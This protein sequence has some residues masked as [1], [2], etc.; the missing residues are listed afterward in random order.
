MFFDASTLPRKKNRIHRRKFKRTDDEM[1][2]IFG[3]IGKAFKKVGKVVKKSGIA[4]AIPGIG[5]FIQQGLDMIPEGG[6]G[7]GGVAKGLSGITTFGNQ[8]LSALDQLLAKPSAEAVDAAGQLVA[9]L[10]DGSKVYQPKKGKDAAALA[11]FKSKAAAKFAEIKQAAAVVIQ[12]EQQQQQQQQEQLA[13]QQQQQ[14]IFSGGGDGGINPNLVY[15][16]G[17]VLIVMMM[18]MMMNNRN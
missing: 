5:G 16:G 15:M 8:V 18:M 4:G 3:S 12:Q 10:S 6:G 14:S 11:D 7:G 13:A 9:A 2:G 1:S 17:G